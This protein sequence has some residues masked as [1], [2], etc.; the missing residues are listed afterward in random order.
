MIN[1][2]YHVGK[3]MLYADP[4]CQKFM[5]EHP[6]EFKKY[7]CGPG[8]FFDYLVP[9]TIYLLSITDACAI[10][11]WGYR[12][13]P[14]AS[15]ADRKEH[16]KILLNNSIRIIQYHTKYKSLYRL[17]MSRIKFYYNM[18][19]F[20]GGPSYWDS[21]NRNKDEQMVVIPT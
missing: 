15:S 16:D 17:R 3:L 19:R 2:F 20:G 1:A 21:N 11:D 4:L 10:H 8:G 5:Q 6:D 13:S 18:V 14:N 7:G 12:H 9:D